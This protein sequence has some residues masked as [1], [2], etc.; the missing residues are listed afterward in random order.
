MPA[1]TNKSILVLFQNTDWHSNQIS[2][3][4]YEL[5]SQAGQ[6]EYY[7]PYQALSVH[8]RLNKVF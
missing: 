5:I 4:T 1:R 7:S 3:M 2:F 6:P 8:T